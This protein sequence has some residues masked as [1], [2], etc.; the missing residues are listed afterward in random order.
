MLGGGKAKHGAGNSCGY[1]GFA[2][3]ECEDCGLKMIEDYGSVGHDG[4]TLKSL[5]CKVVGRWNKVMVKTR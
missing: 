5:Y 3:V 4:V 2:Y 1:S